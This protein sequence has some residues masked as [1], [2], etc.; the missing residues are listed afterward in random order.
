MSPWSS[1]CMISTK[2]LVCLIPNNSKI[3]YHCHCPQC[4]ASYRRWTFGT[5]LVV[6]SNLAELGN[7]QTFINLSWTRFTKELSEVSRC[8]NHDKLAFGGK[9]SSCWWLSVWLNDTNRATFFKVF[10][11]YALCPALLPTFTSLSLKYAYLVYSRTILLVIFL[12]AF[13][14][15]ESVR[16]FAITFCPNS[17]NEALLILFQEARAVMMAC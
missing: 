12:G 9:I 10:L 7:K 1:E 13:L 15:L 14:N 5:F 2:R 8:E 6:Y 3:C 4:A 17:P 11:F 16:V